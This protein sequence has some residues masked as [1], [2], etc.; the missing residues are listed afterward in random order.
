M[1]DDTPALRW[2]KVTDR[3]LKRK[4]TDAWNIISDDQTRSPFQ[5]SDGQ[6]SRA[7]YRLEFI[8]I[9]AGLLSQHRERRR[10][11]AP[12]KTNLLEPLREKFGNA[13]LAKET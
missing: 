8:L 12:I 4:I 3:S 6:K 5:I 2:R 10:G 13:G 11:G 9:E 1:A 7:F